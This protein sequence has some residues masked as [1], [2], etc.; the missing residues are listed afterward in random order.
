M[1]MGETMS[2]GANVHLDYHRERE[3]DLVRHADRANM[4][5]QFSRDAGRRSFLRT[6]WERRFFL[7]PA[8]AAGIPETAPVVAP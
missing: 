5:L 8:T 1:E 3:R 7:R 2:Y 6:A 4:A